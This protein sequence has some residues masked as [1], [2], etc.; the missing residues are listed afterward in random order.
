MRSTLS[1]GDA[2]RIRRTTDAQVSGAVQRVAVP[3]SDLEQHAH[4]GEG[5]WTGRRKGIDLRLRP[6]VGGDPVHRR[7]RPAR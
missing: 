4:L 1:F 6:L 5:R 2:R 3:R 7:Y